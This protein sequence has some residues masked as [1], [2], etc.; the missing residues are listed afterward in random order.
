MV[1]GA[2]GLD[3]VAENTL[4]WVE[5]GWGTCGGLR[6]WRHWWGKF[7]LCCSASGWVGVRA[8][9][10]ALGWCGIPSG[11]L[12]CIG[13]YLD[14]VGHVCHRALGSIV[15]GSKGSTCIGGPARDV[16]CTLE[17]IGMARGG[18]GY[19]GCIR[20]VSGTSESVGVCSR[21]LAKMH[22]QPQVCLP[23]ACENGVPQSTSG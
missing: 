12:S 20:T 15:V 7:G 6:R 17:C 10:N 18:L 4:G 21:G 23:T 8:A 9:W 11:R 2:L 22:G 19:V 13:I 1:G 5:V 16:T 14:V 3:K